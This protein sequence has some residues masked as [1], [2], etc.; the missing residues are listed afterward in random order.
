[1]ARA[2]RRAAGA[3]AAALRAAGGARRGDALEPRLPPSRSRGSVRARGC[4][5]RRVGGRARRPRRDR[6]AA[7][8]AR[9][10][11]P[12]GGDRRPLHQAA[13]L[14]VPRALL[15]EALGSSHQQSLPDR[16]QEGA[17]VRGER[18]RDDLRPALG[19]GAVR[20]P[21][22][23]G[24]GRDHRPEGGR[25][26]ARRR[27]HRLH[28]PARLSRLRDGE[29]GDPALERVP[30]V[31]E[32]PG[33]VQRTRRRAGP[34]HGPPRV[35]RRR[36]VRSSPRA[37]R[38]AGRGVRR[39]AESRGLLR[40]LRAR[41]PP[42]PGRGGAGARERAR[43]DRA[44]AHRPPPR[45]AQPRVSP[46][47]RRQLQHQADPP[48]A[49]AGAVVRGSEDPGG[50]DRERRAAA[51][52]ARGGRDATGGEGRAA[53]G[54]APVLRARHVGD[55]ED[56]GEAQG[57]GR[58]AAGAVLTRHRRGGA[59]TRIA[60]PFVLA[61]LATLGA[62]PRRVTTEL[63]P[64]LDLL[65][66]NQGIRLGS[67]V[68]G[69]QSTPSLPHFQLLRERGAATPNSVERH[70]D[71]TVYLSYTPP[72]TPAWYDVRYA[73]DAEDT[74]TAAIPARHGV[75]SFI[76][77]QTDNLDEARWLAPARAS[78]P[79]RGPVPRW[80][81]IPLPPVNPSPAA[82]R[83]LARPRDP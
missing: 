50:R 82:L 17:R 79:G 32:R 24:Q 3:R 59:G 66:R 7:A 52:D 15:A 46:G 43:A 33:A 81:V 26:G 74:R 21:R 60:L 61:G 38:S 23:P 36:P 71:G 45:R 62:A 42:P 56:A 41:L 83:D 68:G 18:V 6:G 16:A 22:P 25:A 2:R 77:L 49:R 39:G 28:V 27:P 72:S 40:E 37:G 19:P 47:L 11:A 78:P 65:E 4:L 51:A 13:R 58:G 73:D 64:L 57:S 48:R 14:P 67:A 75:R 35:D 31:A 5:P 34:E 54:A 63:E 80:L 69:D 44:E 30:A 10:A 1:R 70:G 53:R 76:D 20:D 29:P 9:R 12:P 8:H 55:G